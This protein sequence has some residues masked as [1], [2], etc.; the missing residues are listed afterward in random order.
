M[1]DLKVQNIVRKFVGD[2]CDFEKIF[3]ITDSS[4][5]PQFI[6]NVTMQNHSA[7]NKPW[8]NQKYFVDRTKAVPF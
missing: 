2:A 6:F 3:D 5:K 7:Y 4:D 1:D 8:P